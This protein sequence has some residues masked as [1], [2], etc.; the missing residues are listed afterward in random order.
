M[1]KALSFINVVE[2]AMFLFI[3]R[4]VFPALTIFE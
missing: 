1:A 3:L 4:L 2:K